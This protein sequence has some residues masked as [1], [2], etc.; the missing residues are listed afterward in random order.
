MAFDPQRRRGVRIDAELSVHVVGVDRG[1]QTRLCNI[2]VSGLYVELAGYVGSTGT[3]EQVEVGTL[4][5]TLR[6]SLLAVVVRTVSVDDLWQGKRVAGVAFEFLLEHAR[7]RELLHEIVRSVAGEKLTQKHEFEGLS[8]DAH[9]HA[10]GADR[11]ARVAG[12][13]A[14]AIVIETS[15]PLERGSNIYLVVESPRHAMPLEVSGV[16]QH[17]VRAEER[18]YRVE[19]RVGNRTD[20]P[21]AVN[22]LSTAMNALLSEAVVPD[23]PSRLHGASADL[24]GA[25]E[26]VSLPSLVSFLEFERLSGTLSLEQAHGVTVVYISEGRIIDVDG[27]TSAS[28]ART[29]LGRALGASQGTFRLQLGPTSRADRFGTASSALVLDLLRQ[30]D[31]SANGR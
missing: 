28:D 10:E 13:T 16:V 8:L 1:A 17:T 2:S 14:D 30:I 12:L 19:V 25:L 31:E 18:R 24:S 23:A 29:L 4:D 9:V 21:R 15:W 3:V 26:R 22:D 27:A 11:P 7:E 20:G 5:G 6:V